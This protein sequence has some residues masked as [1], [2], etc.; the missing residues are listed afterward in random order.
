MNSKYMTGL[1]L[2]LIFIIGFILGANILG[3]GLFVTAKYGNVELNIIGD[4]LKFFEHTLSEKSQVQSD[5]IAS[6]IKNLDVNHPLSGA[7]RKIS[8]DTEGPWA[9]VERT[10]KIVIEESIK[11][12][13]AKAVDYAIACDGSS[14]SK[15][16]ILIYRREKPTS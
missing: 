16:Y 14:F 3:T 6:V 8:K 15:Q 5:L 9:Q 11:L 2:F 10:V 1:A 4:K 7:L 13:S 12:D